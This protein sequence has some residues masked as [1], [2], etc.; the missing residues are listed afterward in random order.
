VLFHDWGLTDSPDLAQ[1]ILIFGGPSDPLGLAL[2]GGLAPNPTQALMVFYHG[3]L[4]LRGLKR[5]VE[6]FKVRAVFST[7]DPA[8]FKKALQ[9]DPVDTEDET[10]RRDMQ[11]IFSEGFFGPMEELIRRWPSQNSS[12]SEDWGECKRSLHKFAGGAG[13]C[14]FHRLGA[15]AKIGEESLA[16]GR[17]PDGL[18]DPAQLE[19]AMCAAFA[20]DWL[21]PWPA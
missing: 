6:A 12:P 14:G 3:A 1:A 7:P 18:G 20:E 15:L 21:G 2:L 4:D 16:Q 19:A 9:P 5:L 8:S 17:L 10:F 13:T 11:D